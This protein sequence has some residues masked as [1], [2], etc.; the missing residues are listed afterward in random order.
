[1]A[2]EKFQP[3]SV[4]PPSSN[5]LLFRLRCWVDLQL[6]TIA[7]HLKPQMAQLCGRILDVGAGE[8]PWREWLPT[9]CCYQ[10]I[11]VENAQDYGMSLDKPNVAYFD[12]VKIPFE[13]ATFDGAICIE[14]LEHAA[15]PQGLLSEIARVLK[16]GAPLLMTVP[17]SA[18]RH[19][20]P[21]DY[22]RFTRERLE[23]LFHMNGFGQI[24]IRERGNDVGVIANK[25]IV[26]T[27]RLL[28]PEHW[29]EAAWS[30]PLALPMGFIAVTMLCAAHISLYLARGSLED[31]LGYFARGVRKSK[32]VDL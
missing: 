13:D 26:L 11:D 16:E 7:T 5:P 22:H 17:W 25:M 9:N 23:Q 30:I 18:R 27:I 21:H 15:D 2:E 31:P 12:G 20:I 29:K 8:S 4:K 3:I 14:V 10:G 24:E 28:R 32:A 19:H 6:G 1:M